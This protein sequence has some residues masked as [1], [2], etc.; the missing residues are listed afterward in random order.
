MELVLSQAD[1]DGLPAALREQLFLHLAGTHVRREGG[2]EAGAQLDREQVIAVLR[3]ISF[4]HAGEHLRALLARLA[5]GEAARPPTRARLMEALEVD[6]P[7]LA[8]DLASLDRMVTKVTGRPAERLSEYD[9][10]TDSY[11]VPA[12]TRALL[13]DVLA[14]MKASGKQEEPLW[15]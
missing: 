7:H 14:T 8:R 15:E 2:T 6:G 13:R 12:A 1:L 3:E 10:A 9:K 4:H 5:Y 11:A